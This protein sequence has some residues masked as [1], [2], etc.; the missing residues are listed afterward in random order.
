MGAALPP[1]LELVQ[2]RASLLKSVKSYSVWSQDDDEPNQAQ[3]RETRGNT[4]RSGVKSKVSMADRE[5]A[6]T[7]MRSLQN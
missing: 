3:F 1:E 7:M 5:R 6:N 4:F 2:R